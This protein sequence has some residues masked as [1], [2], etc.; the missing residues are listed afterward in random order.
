MTRE[1]DNSIKGRFLIELKDIIYS[2]SVLNYDNS[3]VMARIRNIRLV[4]G[5]IGKF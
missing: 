4:Y 5:K 1:E 3:D 2:I